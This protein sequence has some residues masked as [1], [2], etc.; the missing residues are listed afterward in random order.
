[1][2]FFGF[3]ESYPMLGAHLSQTRQIDLLRNIIENF[4]VI[5]NNLK[6]Y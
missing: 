5:V 1:V 3:Y 6:I 4:E 2:A